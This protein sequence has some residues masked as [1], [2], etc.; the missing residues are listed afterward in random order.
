MYDISMTNI[1]CKEFKTTTMKD[2]L[3]IGG[4][5]DFISVT[6]TKSGKNPGSEMAFLTIIDSTGSLDSVIMFP[7]KY[8]EYKNILF[9]GNVIILKGN[10]SKTGD[11]LIVEKAYI[12][13]A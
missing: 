6:K 12:P 9:I 3:I 10:K 1:T 8:K 2:N 11:G 7:E 4:E 5:I 13:R